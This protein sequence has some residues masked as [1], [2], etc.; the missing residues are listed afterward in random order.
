MTKVL[1][2]C[3]SEWRNASRD[4]RELSICRDL[5]FEVMVLAKGADGVED[6][7][8]GFRVLRLGTRPLGDRVPVCI[9]R[10]I[11]V[12]HWAKKARDL[13]PD[14]I[15][16]HDLLGLLVAYLSTFFLKRNRRPKLVYDSH[17]FELGR[18][19][20]RSKLSLFFVK[21]IEGFLINR[22]VFAIMVNDSI[23]DKVQNIYKL[24]QRPLV[25]R[26]TPNT[27]DVID[28]ITKEMH[29]YYCEKVKAPKDSFVVMYHGGLIPGRGIETLLKLLSLN[30]NLVG[31]ILGDGSSEYIE[32]LHNMA[33][34]LGVNTRVFFLPAVPIKDLWRYV[35][36]ADAG[37]ILIPAL[38]ENH[39]LCLPNKFFEN[40]QA[41][42][43]VLCPD[44]P[45][46]REIISEYDNGIT[47]N[48]DDINDLNNKVEALRND[49]VLYA[50][51]KNGAIAAKRDLCWEKEGIRLKE[52][53]INLIDGK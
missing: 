45:A 15:S 20:N 36:A 50:K 14:I 9:N 25:V 18:N 28:T 32:S 40:I 23:A 51:K 46:M 48:I 41:E 5:E 11:S 12:F 13:K 21:K 52:A 30:K 4:K 39:L 3:C 10:V 29:D 1:K 19:S 49:K 33:S 34:C 26:S 37:L 47:Y 22:C 8:D 44:Y 31:I 27:W 7:V 2:I 35:G 16:G 42:T 53:Y 24:K 38:C 6:I 43:P 17:E